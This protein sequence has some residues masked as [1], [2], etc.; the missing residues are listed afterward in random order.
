MPERLTDIDDI[1]LATAINSRRDFMR[2]LGG[3]RLR[4]GYIERYGSAGSAYYQE[5][6][7]YL[8]R[9]LNE[10]HRREIAHADT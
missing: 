10:Q 9:L 3:G 2:I 1:Q 7:E 4:V 6:H 5:D 8:I